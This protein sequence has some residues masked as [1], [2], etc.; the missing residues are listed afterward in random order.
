MAGIYF[1]SPKFRRIATRTLI[2]L[3]ILNGLNIFKLFGI[4]T[5]QPMNFA[6]VPVTWAYIVSLLLIFSFIWLGDKSR[7]M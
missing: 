3:V 5:S 7:G 4:N 2:I 6:G 1:G